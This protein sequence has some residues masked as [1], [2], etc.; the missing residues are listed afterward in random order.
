MAPFVVDEVVERAVYLLSFRLRQLGR[1]FAWKGGAKKQ[2]AW[3]APNA[4]LHAI[5][6]LLLNAVDAAEEAGDAARVQLR[7]LQAGLGVE[8]RVS[9]EGSGI[10]PEARARIFEPRFTTKPP[11]KGTGLGLH[12]AR[13]MMRSHGGSVRLVEESD[14][15]RLPWA[16]TEFTVEIPAKPGLAR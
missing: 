1:R 11:G 14:P 7:V 5:T 4:V 16:R 8:V 13:A 12:I 6:N 2:S 10:A 15:Q 9:D 3:G